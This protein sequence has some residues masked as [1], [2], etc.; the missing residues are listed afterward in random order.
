MA[1]KLRWNLLLQYKLSIVLF[2]SVPTASGLFVGGVCWLA[3]KMKEA[4][5]P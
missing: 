5:L 4:V 3:F 1:Q 2:E